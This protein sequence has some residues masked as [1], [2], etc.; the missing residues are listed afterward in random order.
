MAEQPRISQVVV[1]GASAGGIEALSTLV[2][3]LP[4]EFP[5]PLVIAQHLDPGRP[6]HLA[7]ILARRSTLP[8]QQVVDHAPL[9][10]GVV[11]VVPVNRHVEITDHAISLRTR[12]GG[13]AMPSIDL[14]LTTA[15]PVFGENLIAVIL[16]GAGSDGAAGA[17]AVKEAGRMVVI[18]NPRTAQFAGMPAA[19]AP[20]LVDVVADL[21]TIGPLLHDLLIGADTPATPAE[22]HTLKALLDHLQEAS[23]IDF[24]QYKLPTIQRR[25]QRRMAATGMHRLADYVQYL[26]RHPEE[27]E[28]LVSTF[29][30]K[31]TEFFRDPELFAYRRDQALPEIVAAARGRDREIRLWSAGCATGE[32]AYSLATLL[33]EVLGEE[34]E[35]FTVRTFATDLDTAAVAYARRG[36]YPAN[37]LA[38]LPRDLVERYFLPF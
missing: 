12:D 22:N 28:R 2:A 33:A 3:T 4:A 11:F 32:E 37:A 34:L 5:A 36:I 27:Y 38:T 29:L 9:Q 6:S 19:L 7:Q 23:G 15:A 21:E 8:V 14:L 26:Q 30:I 18:Q 20:P 17:R 24:S 13:R 1:V 16:T 10:N 25:L 31:V 35:R